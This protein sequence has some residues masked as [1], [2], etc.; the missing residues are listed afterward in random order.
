[1]RRC[2]STSILQSGRRTEDTR[3]TT[4]HVPDRRLAAERALIPIGPIE[5]YNL[6]PVDGLTLLLEDTFAF[7][8]QEIRAARFQ[9]A[10]G[11]HEFAEGMVRL[12]IALL[13]MRTRARY[14]DAGYATFAEYLE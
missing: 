9:I 14:L 5:Q 8:D 3:M 12:G 11:A 10:R 6:A 2:G 1:M 13:K 7:L 4:N